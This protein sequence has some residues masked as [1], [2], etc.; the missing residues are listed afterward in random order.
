V[1]EIGKKYAEPTKKESKS[2]P[3]VKRKKSK[4]FMKRKRKNF[5]R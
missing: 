5:G 4:R 2:E 1:Q 3:Q